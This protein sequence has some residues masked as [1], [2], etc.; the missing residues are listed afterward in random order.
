MPAW[1]P[2][3][4]TRIHRSG[5]PAV[6]GLGYSGRPEAAEAI[7]PLATDH[8]SRVRLFVA[9][10]LGRLANPAG[11]PV[12]MELAED[13]DAAVRSAALKAFGTMGTAE[14]V[15][16]LVG[17]AGAGSPE[18]RGAVA[19]ALA[20]H[21]RADTSTTIGALATDEGHPVVLGRLRHSGGPRIR[22]PNRLLQ[23]GPLTPTRRS[24]VAWSSRSAGSAPSRLMPSSLA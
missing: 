11:L 10:S 22:P 9:E 15:E 2:A 24:A 1:S 5:S 3:S 17:R 21:L 6:S 18:T 7:A 23:P 8:D 20:H 4:S 12:A 13:N 19:E 16:A 14:A